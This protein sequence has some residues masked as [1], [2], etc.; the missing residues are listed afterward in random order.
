MCACEIGEAA[1]LQRNHILGHRAP[2]DRYRMIFVVSKIGGS[3]VGS[4]SSAWFL[5]LFD[6]GASGSQTA[7]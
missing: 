1:K 4:L 3:D 2:M 6:W 7:K 5:P